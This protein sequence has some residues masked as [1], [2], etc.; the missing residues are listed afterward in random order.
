MQFDS[1]SIDSLFTARPLHEV[2]LPIQ[3]EPRGST[4]L[5]DA[6]ENAPRFGMWAEPD[7]ESGVWWHSL[8]E[9]R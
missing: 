2:G 5:L 9:V 1:H 4:P 6:L 8:L 7:P 3:F